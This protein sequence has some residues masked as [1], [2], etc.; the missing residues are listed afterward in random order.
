MKNKPQTF[1]EF[2]SSRPSAIDAEGAVV[3]GVKILGY[4]SSNG[5]SYDKAAVSRA[6]GMYEGRSVY[7][8]HSANPAASRSMNE[9]AGVIRNVAER[10]DGLYGDLHLLKTHPNTARVLEAAQTM[11]EAFGLSHNVDGRSVKKNGR[12]VV[13][14]ILKV[15][16]VD[17][18]AEP[19]TTRGLFESQDGTLPAEADPAESGANMTG[20]KTMS[21]EIKEAVESATAKYAEQ[22]ARLT[23]QVKT[24]GDALEA[25]RAAKAALETAGKCRAILE[26]CGVE[27]KPFMVQALSLL[28][29][30]AARKELAESW[31]PVAPAAPVR[32]AG[33]FT[34]TGDATYRRPENAKEF[35]ARLK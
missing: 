1:V 6:R 11:P 3:R 26:S 21:E 13:E 17:V 34:G 9:K 7:F 12:N 23:E 14:E 18:V 5:R 16:S 4:E 8:D 10:D 27:P 2:T 30:D 20:H 35:A 15:R 29:D 22:V 25:E 24:L 19:A 31:K 33:G 32:S 28:S